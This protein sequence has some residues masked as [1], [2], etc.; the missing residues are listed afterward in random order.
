MDD[1]NIVIRKAF[2]GYIVTVNSPREDVMS[3]ALKEPHV[4]LTLEDVV[5]FVT[6]DVLIEVPEV[7]D[8]IEQVAP[9]N[10]TET[11]ASSTDQVEVAQAQANTQ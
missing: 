7:K 11:V 3:A 8:E 9:L 6:T 10:Q 5:A 1:T 2:E 4:F